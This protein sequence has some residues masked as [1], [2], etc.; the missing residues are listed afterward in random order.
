M[1][2]DGQAPALPHGHSL[3]HHAG[4]RYAPAD[5]RGKR[6]VGKIAHPLNRAALRSATPACRARPRHSA[7]ARDAVAAHRQ[8][9]ARCSSAYFPVPTASI[10]MPSWFRT[11]IRILFEEG[12]YCGK[13]IYDVDI[14]EAALQNA[15]SRQQGSQPRSSGRHLRARGSRLGYRGGRGISLTL[16]RRG[17]AP[18]SLGARRLAIA[19]LDF[20]ARPAGATRGAPL[21]R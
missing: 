9:R 19:A 17:G 14:F 6:L 10:L 12:S 1:P 15:H 20:R 3:R 2:I 21:F 11:F 13:G 5:R 18:A 7:A 16:R 4:C 8:P